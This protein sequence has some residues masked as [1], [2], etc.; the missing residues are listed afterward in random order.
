[1]VNQ[2]YTRMSRTGFVW[3]LCLFSCLSLF[4]AVV[5]AQE[6]K[7]QLD[8]EMVALNESLT[9]TL[10][11][12]LDFGSAFNLFDLNT[13]NIAAPDTRDL[14]EDFEVIDRQQN[15]RV[16]II[17]NQNQSVI[18]WTYTLMPKRT[19]TLEIEPITYEGKRSEALQV[20]VRP[21]ST[22]STDQAPELLVEAEVDESRVYVQQQFILT[23]RLKYVNDLIRGEMT[24]PDHENALF[25]QLGEQREYSQYDR[26]LH[27]RVVERKYAVFPRRAG[28]LTVPAV[29]FQGRFLTPRTG[30]QTSRK[31][32]SEAL[33]VQVAPPPDAFTGDYWLPAQGLVLTESWEP[34]V[35]EI[36]LGETLERRIE[37][38]ALGLEGVSLPEL[39]FRDQPGLKVYSETPELGTEDRSTGVLGKRLDTVAYVPTR[40]GTFTLPPIEISWWDVLNN[41]QRTAKVPGRRL[42][43]TAAPGSQTGN[44]QQN[45]Q[46]PG[47]FSEQTANP[48]QS[49]TDQSGFDGDAASA[50]PDS[51]T[52]WQVLSLLL[53]MGWL[54]TAYA[55]WRRQAGQP[56]PDARHIEGTAD[57]LSLGELKK[58]LQASPLDAAE[59]V[60]QWCDR[61]MQQGDLPEASG[62]ELA[63]SIRADL[64]RL[65]ALKYGQEPMPGSDNQD[66]ATLASRIW[67]QL[68]DWEQKQQK[69][70]SPNGLP[71]LY[72]GF[73]S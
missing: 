29:V 64:N 66:A 67:Q 57:M 18:S 45:G 21:A 23:V 62:A 68:A 17:N 11:T 2:Q 24:H 65:Q 35:S 20:V 26:G 31:A 73:R 8:R 22:D 49:R 15:Y 56:R 41:E 69:K 48:R 16:Q 38:Q 46:D 59:L 52:F 44:G 27:Y 3:S 70:G 4:A 14:E 54:V 51:A 33:K 12:E 13:L 6:L 43:V 55:L 47:P 63:F 1:M 10:S 60:P 28:E 40:A 32:E 30:R 50:S 61:R 34:D 25:R 39:T 19:G 42:Q 53:A 7:A 37:W 9:L 71:D 58:R 72:D 5:H 36:Q